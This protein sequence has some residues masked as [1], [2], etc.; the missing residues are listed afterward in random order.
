MLI[1]IFEFFPNALKQ[2]KPVNFLKFS[3]IF[4]SQFI[5]EHFYFGSLIHY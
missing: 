5:Y 1:L 2:L 4:E 3:K